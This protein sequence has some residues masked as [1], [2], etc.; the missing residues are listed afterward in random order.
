MRAGYLKVVGQSFWHLISGNQNLSTE[1]VE[2]L[3]YRAKEH[4]DTFLEGRSEVAN[5]F[6]GEFIADFCTPTGAIDWIRLVEFNSKNM[7]P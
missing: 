3:G 4:N 1:I 5:G 7:N 6:T 2:P